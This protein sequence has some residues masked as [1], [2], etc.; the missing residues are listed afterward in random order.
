MGPEPS[1]PATRVGM[2]ADD[3]PAATRIRVIHGPNLNLL[4][5]REPQVYGTMTLADLDARLV[6][7]GVELGIEIDC[8][9]RNSE[10]AIIDLVH[11]AADSHDALVINPGGYTHTSVAIADALRAVDLPA[12]EVHLSNVYARETFRHVSLTAPACVGVVMGLG[13]ASYDLAIRHL[14]AP[15]AAVP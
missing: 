1:S 5:R 3:R 13:A 8:H 4:G 12:I 9:Q 14:A 11:E 10:G 2:D 15:W 7:L 6:R